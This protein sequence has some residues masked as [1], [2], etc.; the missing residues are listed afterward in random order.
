MPANPFDNQGGGLDINALLEQATQM[1]T[2][3]QDA[4]A[5]LAE[6]TVQ[7][8]VGG[9]SVAVTLNGVGDLVGVTVQPG[10]VSGDDPDSLEEL[11][12][13]IVAAFRDAKVR[14]DELAAQALGPL[15]GGIPG[16]G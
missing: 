3:L 12:D 6:A 16:L 7:G 4:Q 13:L 8:S 10:V 1:Q 9:G 11:G 2:R 5:Q 14:A 15:A